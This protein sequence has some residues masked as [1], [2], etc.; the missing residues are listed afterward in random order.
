MPLLRL[1]RISKRFPGVEALTDVDF[2]LK[3]GEAHILF[4]ENG[5]GKSTLISLIAGA[6]VPSSGTMSFKGERLALSSVNEARSLGINAVFQE[7]SLV[8]QL[9]VE[10]N[11]F[12]GAEVTSGMSL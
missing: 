4:G 12:L 5:A 11:I 3:A 2:D 1:E 8:P 7:F 9:T 10:E 6:D